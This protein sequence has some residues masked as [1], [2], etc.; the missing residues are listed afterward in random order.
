MKR[1]YKMRQTLCFLLF[2]FSGAAKLAIVKRRRQ[3][4]GEIESVDKNCPRNSPCVS[5]DSCPFALEQFQQLSKMDRD[6]KEYGELA[7]NIKLQ[8]CNKAEKA[9]C[10][11]P[12]PEEGEDC[13]WKDKGYAAGA[14]VQDLFSW[15]FEVRCGQEGRRVVQG[16]QW[17][18]V[19]R[20]TRYKTP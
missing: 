8:V 2:T 17:G 5:H 16:R 20:D 14:P 1:K 7:S 11:Q 15:W 12:E 13:V 10:C 9:V 4:A 18:E 6:S 3:S 19:V